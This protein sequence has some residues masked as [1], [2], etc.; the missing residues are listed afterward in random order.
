MI[1]KR[2]IALGLVALCLFSTYRY[3][4]YGLEAKQLEGQL[5]TTLKLIENYKNDTAQKGETIIQGCEDFLRQKYEDG[6]FD[7]KVRTTFG[8]TSWSEQK[9]DVAPI[10]ACSY[11]DKSTQL[12]SQGRVTGALAH[13]DAGLLGYTKARVTVACKGDSSGHVDNAWIVYSKGSFP[14][15]RLSNKYEL[16][17]TGKGVVIWETSVM[18]K[19][20]FMFSDENIKKSEGI[21]ESSLKKMS[22]KSF[23]LEMKLSPLLVKIPSLFVLLGTW[24]I[25][26]IFVKASL[27]RSRRVMSRRV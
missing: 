1:F 5:Q 16:L 8:N 18:Q 23:L 6:I 4:I 27:R 25:T 15:K 19:K 2:I 14:F 7:V 21:Y 3:V 9:L 10:R 17:R 22:L 26:I 12:D 13:C 20:D 11:A 24:V